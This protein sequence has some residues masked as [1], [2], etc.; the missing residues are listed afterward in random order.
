MVMEGLKALVGRVDFGQVLIAPWADAVG[1]QARCRATPG[2]FGLGQR[3]AGAKPEAAH[4]VDGLS[5]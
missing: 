2:G 5:A 1:M 3:G 4:V